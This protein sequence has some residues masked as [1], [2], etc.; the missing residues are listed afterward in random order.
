MA[1][2]AWEIKEIGLADGAAQLR[3]PT[4]TN[5]QPQPGQY[6]LAFNS[7]SGEPLPIPLFFAGNS[8]ADWILAGQFPP[9]WQPGT[10]LNW[11]GPLG[12][13]FHLPP[14]S[15]RVGLVD[16]GNQSFSLPAL[17]GLALTQDASMVWYSRHLPD[18]LP[19]SVEV[20]PL[21]SLADAWDWADY[22]AIECDYKELAQLTAVLMNPQ[23]RKPGCS[24]EFLLHTPLTCGG[25]SEC[26]VCAVRTKTGW[27]LACKDG[28]VFNIDQLEMPA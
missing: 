25:T 5:I 12:R 18:W 14:A 3:V 22:L 1:D 4:K 28:P 8:T 9:H 23:G 24:T 13:G 15:R 26:G 11:R 21:E 27:K 2:G 19:P 6:F 16:W 7:G 10:R 20:L 17:V